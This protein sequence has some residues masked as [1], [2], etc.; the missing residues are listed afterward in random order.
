MKSY[1]SENAKQNQQPASQDGT[2]CVH[3][4][5]GYSSAKILLAFVALVGVYF[6]FSQS[7]GF[8]PASIALGFV[9]LWLAGA[10]VTLALLALSGKTR[11]HKEKPVSEPKTSPVATTDIRHAA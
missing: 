10:V 11:D 5:E 9:A 6:L 4:Q 3:R 8:E 7:S 2:S 1:T